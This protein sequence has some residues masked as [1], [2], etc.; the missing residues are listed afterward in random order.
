MPSSV[1]PESPTLFASAR[2]RANTTPS[3]T[4]PSPACG[5]ITEPP[6]ATYLPF[7]FGVEFEV[8]VR[9]RASLIRTDPLPDA[10]APAKE[11][12]LYSLR[13]REVVAD[14]LSASDLPCNVFD[15][16][17]EL[18]DYSKWNA[19][20]DGSISKKHQKDGFCTFSPITVMTGELT[21]T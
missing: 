17:E 10:H 2:P 6:P 12:R 5:I 16:E 20:L 9:P 11:F 1:P 3:P 7:H 4:K 15:P 19:M 21:G 13:L 8:L 14:L 18:P